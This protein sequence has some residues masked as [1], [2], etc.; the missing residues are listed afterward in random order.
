M[1]YDA[2]LT[3]FSKKIIKRNTIT[4]LECSIYIRNIETHYV[5]TRVIQVT[6][7]A[8]FSVSEVL[9]MCYNSD[10]GFSEYES[11]CDEGEEVH[12]Y[13]GPRVIVPEKVVSLNRAVTS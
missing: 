5:V 8:M 4:V 11:S 7:A 12:A 3:Y 10:F 13:R 6:M 9:S 1:S 2:R